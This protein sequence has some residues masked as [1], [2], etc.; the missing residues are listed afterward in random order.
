MM[1]NKDMVIMTSRSGVTMTLIPV[2]ASPPPRSLPACLPSSDREIVELNLPTGVPLIYHL[3][4][5]LRYHSFRPPPPPSLLL[6]THSCCQ[7]DWY[8]YHSPPL[9]SATWGAARLFATARS[10]V[11]AC[12]WP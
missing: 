1:A 4:H 7:Y 2:A 10:T 6:V 11:A 9:A 8:S 5:Q 12:A 3:D